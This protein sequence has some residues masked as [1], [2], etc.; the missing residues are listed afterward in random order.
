MADVR[1]YLGALLTA[2]GICGAAVPSL[3]DSRTPL[4]TG[5]II[6]LLVLMTTTVSLRFV[7]RYLSPAKY[8]PDDWMILVAWG[9]AVIFN[10]I[11][12][13]SKYIVY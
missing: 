1:S 12:L 3:Q 10:A 13:D 11:S 8:G 5:V 7:S 4:I 2:R 9:G 6:L